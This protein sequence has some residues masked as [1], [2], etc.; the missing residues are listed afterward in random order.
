MNQNKTETNDP[1]AG[2]GQAND[3]SA[4]MASIN[5]TENSLHDSEPLAAAPY[6]VSKCLINL[7]A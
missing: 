2:S 5:Q 4:A 3:L 7:K 6:S 1:Q